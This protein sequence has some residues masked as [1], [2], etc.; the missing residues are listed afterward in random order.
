MRIAV[1]ASGSGS[2]LKTILVHAQAGRLSVRPVLVL[3]NNPEA[4][5][6]NHAREH[7]VPVWFKPHRGVS[8]EDFDAEMIREIRA[9]GAE[10][11]ILAG[12]M[13][14]LTPAFIQTFAGRILNLHPAILPSFAGAHGG[15][16]A[17]DYQVR[18]SGCTVHFVDEIMDNGPV[19]IQ[20]AVP[21]GPDD[22]LPD[23][24]TRI[25]ALEHRIYPQAIEWLAQGRLKVQ[26]R[27]VTLLPKS[28]GKPG[29]PP[30]LARAGEGEHGPWLVS[31][32]LEDF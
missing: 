27:K 7:G 9:A 18:I 19:V 22:S 5:A 31:P 6:L 30:G 32:A 29:S 15:R 25:H 10:A 26:G 21:V 16:D 17:L 13:R 1:L 2:N 14:L 3:S 11:V 24:M 4:G 8:R 23:L 28:G 12:Y 20:A